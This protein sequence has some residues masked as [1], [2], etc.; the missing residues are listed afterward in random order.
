M[1]T[2]KYK[3]GELSKI[4]GIPVDTLRYFEKAGLIFP[5]LNPINNYR[6]YDSWDITFLVEYKY[7]RSLEFSM[8]DAISIQ[9]EDDLSTLIK[10]TSEQLDHFH[11][12][13]FYYTYL[14]ECYRKNK[15]QLMRIPQE[16]DQI[17]IRHYN[18]VDYFYHRHDY[19]YISISEGLKI[20]PEW[21]KVFPFLSRFLHVSPEWFCDTAVHHCYDAGFSIDSEYADIFHLKMDA[22]CHHLP[23]CDAVRTIVRSG[24]HGTFSIHLLDPIREYIE[25]NHLK[26][27]GEYYGNVLARTH[28][29]DGFARYMEFY[30]PLC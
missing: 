1:D 11:E 22:N 14:E 15:E 6:Y 23:A 19:E 4:L 25:K 12:R 28:E 13:K 8:S 3:I 10:R 26:I 24:E 27:Q 5:E 7:Y 2:I 16:I 21:W 18:A 20:M 9:H 17:D 29:A 30:I